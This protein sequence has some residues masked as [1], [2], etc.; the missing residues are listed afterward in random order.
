MS[1]YINLFVHT[2]FLIFIIFFIIRIFTN[3]L[4][5]WLKWKQMRLFMCGKLWAFARRSSPWGP[6]GKKVRSSGQ[7]RISN[8]NITRLLYCSDGR[9]AAQGNK[10]EH[11]RFTMAD[12]IVL[13]NFSRLVD[14]EN[15]IFAELM[16][17]ISYRPL[18]NSWQLGNETQLN[19]CS[20]YCPRLKL[21][22]RFFTS[23]FQ[24][25]APGTCAVLWFMT[26]FQIINYS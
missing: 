24:L 2:V 11:G 7:E 21:I 17:I 22:A 5:N 12:L 18:W 6:V 14:T 26:W 15:F 23:S 20:G 1:K 9:S 25:P 10:L 19:Y 8:S 3:Y 16:I 13:Y 4:I